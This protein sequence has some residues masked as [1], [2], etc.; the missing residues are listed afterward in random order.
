LG[1]W[2]EVAQTVQWGNPNIA[3]SQNSFTKILQPDQTGSESLIINNEGELELEYDIAI[4]INSKGNKGGKDYCDGSGGCDEYI[5]NVE[6]G[7][8]NNSSDCTEY[9]DYTNLSTTMNA[10]DSYP[11]TITN[12]NSW[13]GDEC[14]IWVD[15][16]QN[17]EFDDNEAISTNGGPD[18]YTANI[19]PPDDAVGGSTRMRIRL[20]YYGTPEPCGTTSYGEVEDYTIDVVSWLAVSPTAGTIAAGESETISLDF[21]ATDMEENT[22]T[23]DL[24]LSSNDPDEPMIIIPITLIVQE[25]AAATQTIELSEGYQFACFHGL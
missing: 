11:I 5:S 22:Y 10:G 8:I 19:I 21:D 9:G 23:A 6:V 25:G 18:V 1:E 7:E 3:V 17:E 15:W 13:N 12:G 14:M 16:N 20:Q 2:C 24:S 4:S